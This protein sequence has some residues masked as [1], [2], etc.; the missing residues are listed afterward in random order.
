MNQFYLFKYFWSIVICPIVILWSVT[1]SLTQENETKK[2]FFLILFLFFA[3]DE[4]GLLQS[5]FNNLE[6]QSWGMKGYF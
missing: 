1:A 4:K 5:S 6:F 2:T 3:E